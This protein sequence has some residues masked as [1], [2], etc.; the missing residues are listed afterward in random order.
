MSQEHHEVG[1]KG[2]PSRRGELFFQRRQIPFHDLINRSVQV[3]AGPLEAGLPV[4]Q[5]PV[6]PQAALLAVA[7]LQGV[8]DVGVRLDQARDALRVAER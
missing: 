2:L 8:E 1:A 5:V 3:H 7:P 4:A 6:H